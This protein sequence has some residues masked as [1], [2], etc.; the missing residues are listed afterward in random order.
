ME[1]SELKARFD[2]IEFPVVDIMTAKMWVARMDLGTYFRLLY[3][4]K[5]QGFHYAIDVVAAGAEMALGHEVTLLERAPILATLQHIQ[6]HA[7]TLEEPEQL[8][9][10]HC[11]KEL[12]AKKMTRQR[13]ALLAST[14]LDKPISTNAWRKKTDRW[15]EKQGMEPLGQTKRRAR[16]RVSGQNEDA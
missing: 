6:D 14:I 8:I 11:Y 2:S 1:V 10:Q 5:T 12:R 9:L 16:S 15:A 7:K 3:L 13:A 4:I